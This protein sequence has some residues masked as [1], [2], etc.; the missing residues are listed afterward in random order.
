M[1]FGVL[2]GMNAAGRIATVAERLMDDSGL[3]QK[4]EDTGEVAV[5]ILVEGYEVDITLR[6]RE[7]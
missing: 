2:D 6:R 1:G 5:K 4:F 7:E 3:R